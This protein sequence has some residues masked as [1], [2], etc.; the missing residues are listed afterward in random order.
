MGEATP[1]APPSGRETSPTSEN[2]SHGLFMDSGPRHVQPPNGQYRRHLSRDRVPYGDLALG[3]TRLAPSPDD[4]EDSVAA[5][6]VLPPSPGRP[7]QAGQAGGQR[8]AGGPA[9]YVPYAARP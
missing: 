2:L 1:M 3:R 7:A 6:A 9:R 5:S 8:H 4:Q